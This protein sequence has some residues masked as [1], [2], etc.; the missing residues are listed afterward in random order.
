VYP[1][2]ASR[3]CLDAGAARAYARACGRAR[4]VP[5]GRTVL[6]CADTDE[7]R[8]T[9]TDSASRG[10]RVHVDRRRLRG[11]GTGARSRAGGASGLRNKRFLHESPPPKAPVRASPHR[12]VPASGPRL[13]RGARR[14]PRAPART[15]KALAGLQTSLRPR[16][17]AHLSRHARARCHLRRRPRRD[18]SPHTEAPA[19]PAG[20]IR[21][22]LEVPYQ[23]C[24]RSARWR[25]SASTHS[26]SSSSG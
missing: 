21:R 16:T 18:R 12:R 14:A 9:S 13:Q 2:G 1:G 26:R 11:I 23:E 8:V 20:P 19:R 6:E 4:R 24:A 22:A 25:S 17:T 10:A 15:L 5:R 7:G 3:E